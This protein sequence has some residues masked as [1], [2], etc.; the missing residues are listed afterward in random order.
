MPVPPPASNGTPSWLRSEYKKEVP[1]PWDAASSPVAFSN[2][3]PTFILEH[4]TY[5]FGGI[6]QAARKGDIVQFEFMTAALEASYDEFHASNPVKARFARALVHTG[7]P[8]AFAHVMA[9]KSSDG[10]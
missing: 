5:K 4:E 10:T 6:F 3:V 2:G 8:R 1:K 7:L 9:R